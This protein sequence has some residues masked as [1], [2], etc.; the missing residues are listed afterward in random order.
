MRALAKR[1]EAAAEDVKRLVT[2]SLNDVD[3]G[4]GLVT[5]TGAALHRILTQ[6]AE[7]NVVVADIA[8]G[9]KDQAIGLQEVNTRMRDI[10]LVTQ[11]NS[12]MVEEST[13]ASH[14]LAQATMGLKT[15]IQSFTL[16]A[17]PAVDPNEQMPLRASVM[18]ERWSRS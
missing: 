17:T 11:K 18:V 16:T 8:G 10:G 1:S 2:T 6:M 4:V 7:I 5:E 9:S 15:L 3:K 13:A 12:T 14:A